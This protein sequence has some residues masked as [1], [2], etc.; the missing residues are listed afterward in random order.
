MSSKRKRAGRKEGRKEMKI[1]MKRVNKDVCPISY[2]SLF[3]SYILFNKPKYFYNS[4]ISN[5]IE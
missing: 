1:K 4:S 2:V 5:Y 3:I